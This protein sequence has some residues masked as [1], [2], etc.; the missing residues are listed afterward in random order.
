MI[1]IRLAQEV[2]YQLERSNEYD[3]LSHALAALPL[4]Y[5]FYTQDRSATLEVWQKLFLN[6]YDPEVIYGHVLQ[7]SSSTAS[8]QNGL[9][10]LQLEMFF[11][12]RGRYTFCLQ[13]LERTKALFERLGDEEYTMDVTR[14]LGRAHLQLSQLQQAQ[15]CFE[16]ASKIAHRLGSTQGQ[17]FLLADFGSLLCEQGDYDGAL[18]YY[19]QH[20]QLARTYGEREHIS[21]GLANLGR[22]EALR[23]QFRT[24]LDSYEQQS[25]I[26]D[27]I[28]DAP[29]L[30]TCL[31]HIATLYSNLNDME[32]AVQTYQKAIV[33]AERIG[34]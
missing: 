20:L 24:S 8:L 14:R 13:I 33:L 21:V 5:S 16:E 26:L 30:V 3:R 10:L 27:Q 9:V 22:V 23:R 25:E 18:S 4:F 15:R 11:H 6:G 7:K 12:N 2:T 28:S 19:Q 31:I 1:P 29:K 32:G 17:F 34:N